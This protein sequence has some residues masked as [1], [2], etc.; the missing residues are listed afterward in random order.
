MFL[1]VFRKN[2]SKEI[3]T[4][5]LRSYIQGSRE[6]GDLDRIAPP[7]MAWM[8]MGYEDHIGLLDQPHRRFPRRLQR[9]THR[10]RKTCVCD[11]SGRHGVDHRESYAVQELCRGRHSRRGAYRALSAVSE[12]MGTAGLLPGGDQRLLGFEPCVRSGARAGWRTQK[13]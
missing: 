9:L 13:S 8:T 2:T 6:I 10:G 1:K 7:P 5:F 12:R 4:Q 3:I 11:Q